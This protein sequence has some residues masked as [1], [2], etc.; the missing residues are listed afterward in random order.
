MPRG[1]RN[2]TE[3]PTEISSVVVASTMGL[4]ASVEREE[5][6]FDPLTDIV[7]KESGFRVHHVE[8]GSPGEQCGLSSVLDYIVVANGQRLDSDDG[9]FVRMIQEHKDAE[10]KICVFNT[11]TLRAR[12]TILRPTDDWGGNGLLG[13]TIRFDVVQPIE[14]HTLH[15]L[16]V[17]PNSPASAAGLD[18]HNDFILGIG[19][20]LFDGPDEFGEIVRHNCNRPI[21]LYLYNTRSECVREVVIT[22][23]MK[24][25]G[26]GCLGC[27]VGAG[28]LHSLPRRSATPLEKRPTPRPDAL[29]RSEE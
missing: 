29:S 8:P 11:H 7:S 15:V 20:L 17:Y 3:H 6:A 21:R 18:P 16:N 2:P 14:K 10:I 13:I 23:M 25:G 19:D 27:G 24:W 12:E 9:T 4:G 26:D 1:H 28:Y 5:G 22:P